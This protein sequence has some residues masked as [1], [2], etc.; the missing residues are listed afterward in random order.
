MKN[1]RYKLLPIT[2]FPFSTLNSLNWNYMVNI[3]EY[4]TELQMTFLL[5]IILI[6]D[7]I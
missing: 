7:T 3:T 1:C 4:P 2:S 6:N 5:Q